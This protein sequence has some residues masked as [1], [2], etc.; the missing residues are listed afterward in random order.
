MLQL[1]LTEEGEIDIEYSKST[2]A[3]TLSTN[4]PNK[5][6]T[7]ALSLDLEVRIPQQKLCSL[8]WYIRKP[9]EFT[10]KYWFNFIFKKRS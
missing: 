3:H 4:H 1:L 5:E 2:D 9:M 8:E 10:G 6:C 7:F